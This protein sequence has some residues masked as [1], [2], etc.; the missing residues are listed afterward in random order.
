MRPA[1]I[2]ADLRASESISAFA[3]T[4]ITR[5]SAPIVAGRIGYDN[6]EF[7]EGRI[8]DMRPTVDDS[9]VDVVVSNCVLNLV[10]QQEK[11]QLFEEIFRVLRKGGRAVISDIVSDE[12]VPLAMQQD[13][14]LWTNCISGARREDEFLKAFTDAGFYGGRIPARDVE[15]WRTVDGYEFRSLTVEAFK[16]KEGPCFEKLQAVVYKGPFASVV[17]DDGNRIPRG[18]RYAVCEKTFGLFSKQPYRDH[19]EFVE[20]LVEVGDGI[21]FDCTRDSLRHPRATKGQDYDKTTDA[22]ACCAPE[23]GCC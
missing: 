23:D 1:T 18:V 12:D 2:G 11:T 16:G 13:A 5:P 6:V 10:A 15:P 17:D 9:S 4:P 20:P 19:F 22:G 3:S 14:A 8:Q 7:R 21:P